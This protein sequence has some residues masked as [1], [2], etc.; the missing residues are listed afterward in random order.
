[1]KKQASVPR[2]F[3]WNHAEYILRVFRLRVTD[4]RASLVVQWWL[5]ICLAMWGTL[6]QSLVQENSTCRGATK[7]MSH[8]YWSPRSRACALQHE[9]PQ[10]WEVCAW[11]LESSPC[12]QQLEKAQAATKTQCSQ[13]SIFFF[14]FLRKCCVMNAIHRITKGWLSSG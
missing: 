14:F 10:K 3:S 4:A 1:M 12:P 9:K 13:K 6:V 5:S 2:R 11:Q 7:S 8:N